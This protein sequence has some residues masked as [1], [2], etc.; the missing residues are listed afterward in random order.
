MSCRQR[1]P[2]PLSWP[3]ATWGRE[4]RRS[5]DAEAEIFY[6]RRVRGHGRPHRRSRERERVPARASGWFKELRAE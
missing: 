5:N 4:V 1:P 3:T 6:P 2:L